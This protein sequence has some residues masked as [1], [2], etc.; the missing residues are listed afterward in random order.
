MSSEQSRQAII[1]QSRRSRPRRTRRK[2]NRD[3]GT[4][5]VID[6]MPAA[7][8]RDLDWAR[9][10]ERRS[11]EPDLTLVGKAAHGHLVMCLGPGRHLYGGC[12][13]FLVRLGTSGDDAI[14]G[15]CAGR[16]APQVD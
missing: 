13:D 9:E 3:Q 16:E 12:D 10:Y 1:S 8:G 14:E 6:A 7:S 11:G 5:F 15:L 4:S 2:R